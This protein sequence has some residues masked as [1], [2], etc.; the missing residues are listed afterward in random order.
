[1]LRKGR[2]IAKYEF[3][4]LSVEKA[5]RISDEL[6]HNR[7]ITRPMTLSDLYNQDE[8]DFGKQEVVKIGF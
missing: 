7:T 1:L 3:K 2:L 8:P 5:Q 6:G 4:E